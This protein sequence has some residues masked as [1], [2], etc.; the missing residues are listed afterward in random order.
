MYR[1]VVR[2]VDAPMNSMSDA[3]P[4][5]PAIRCSGDYTTWA[6]AL[7]AST[8][9]YLPEFTERTRQ[10]ALKVKRGEAVYERDSVLFDEVQHS[11][12]LLAGLLR[13]AV[14]NDGRLT[15]FDF[16]GGFGTSYFQCRAFLDVVAP[17][18]WLV[19]DQASHVE[20]GRRDFETDELR[21]FASTDE[22]FATYR[23][24]VLLLSGVLPWIPEPYDLLEHLLAARVSY[25][26]IDR[27][28]FLGRDRDRLTVQHG[29][30]EIYP[31][32][33]PTWFFSESRLRRTVEGGGY[34]LVV[35][36]DG[37]DS[38]GPEDEPAYTKGFVFRGEHCGAS[39]SPASKAQ[40]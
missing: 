34:R 35:A 33:Y 19:V 25:L 40:L 30:F 26:I 28:F 14:E 16:G 39:V 36:F 18:R 12:P 24:D 31:G 8:G 17:L 2:I 11:F 27:T 15:V 20:I 9:Y 6:E 38:V 10:A 4:G 23:P 29:P 1:D 5:E 13:A 32:S 37:F 7:A 22:V 21:F 3:A